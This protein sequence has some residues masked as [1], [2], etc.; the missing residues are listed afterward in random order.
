[1]IKIHNFCFK[2]HFL[3]VLP[4][5]NIT[6][7]L[8]IGH[9]FQYFII[10]IIIK[11]KILQGYIIKFILGFDHAGLSAIIKFKSK[12]KIL[13]QKKYLIK[14]YLYQLKYINF[15]LKKTKINFTLNKNY[16][17]IVKNGFN[18][19]YK[20]KL[21]IVKK[22]FLNCCKNKI[23]SDCEIEKKI[24]TKYL[25]Y[26]KYKIKTKTI[27]I[28]TSNL[29]SLFYNTFLISKIKFYN[30]KESISPFKFKIKI[31]S[32][33]INNLSNFKKYSPNINNFDFLMFLKKKASIIINYQKKS[34]LYN[35]EKFNFRKKSILFYKKKNK[36]NIFKF[37]L[38]N[39]YIV[40]IKK[41]KSFLKVKKYDNEKINN[42][43][44]DQWFLNIKKILSFK[45]IKKNIFIKNKKYEKIFF[46]WI[47]NISNWCISRQINWGTKIPIFLDKE[48]NIYQKKEYKFVKYYNNKDVFDTWFNSSFWIIF[49]YNKL[50]KT[51]NIIVSGFDIIFF[52]IIK[53]LINN[54]F[55]YKKPLIK[56]IIIHGLIKDST[57]KIS[58]S[59][60]NVLNFNQIKKNI[61]KIR[62]YLIKDI[63]NDINISIFKFQTNKKYFI[64]TILD[65]KI[66]IFFFY[67]IKKL[68]IKKYL[69]YEFERNNQNILKKNIICK[70]IFILITKIFFPIK[71]IFI[72][73][74]WNFSLNFYINK[75]FDFKFLIIIKINNKILLIKTHTNYFVIFF[76]IKLIFYVK[77]KNK[78]I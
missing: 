63:F 70:K 3:I 7:E 35:S 52:W 12:K 24:F 66:N 47:K 55:I 57:K 59:T 32:E 28:S 48:K 11:L 58:K 73:E 56:K 25:Y 67:V 20:K 13:V 33:Q 17:N 65:I 21:I 78:T 64:N 8:H 62:L 34:N 37:L 51:N 43:L 71:K 61:N 69:N 41:Y 68:I 10:D 1:M 27:I 16:E 72:S 54:I 76:K 36:N 14:R 29:K 74:N 39:N 40:C 22:Q 50:K 23:I 45:K 31:Y 18:Y 38:K 15:L 30:D 4:P 77:Q 53:M 26:I 75:L 49:V 19:Y 9:F 5:P 2:K 44:F 60:N 46:I 42:L 6:G